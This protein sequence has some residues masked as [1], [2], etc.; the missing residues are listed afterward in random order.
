M[1]YLVKS[2]RAQTSGL[3][4][5]SSPNRFTLSDAQMH[6]AQALARQRLTH[7]RRTEPAASQRVRVLEQNGELYAEIWIEDEHGTTIL[8]DD[9]TIFLDSIDPEVV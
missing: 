4:Q 8:P 5:L 2:Y 3:D 1:F 6:L 9:P 7:G